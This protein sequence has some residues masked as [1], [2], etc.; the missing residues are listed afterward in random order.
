MSGCLLQ[1]RYASCCDLLMMLLGTLCAIAHGTALPLLMLFFGDLSDSFIYQDISSG[2]ARNVSNQTGMDINCSSIFN[3]TLNDVTFPDVNITSILQS[4]PNAG[5][6]DARCLLGAEFIS[7][8]NITVL[9][10][11]GIGVGVVIVATLQIC[12]FQFAAEQQVYN[13]RLRYYRAIMRQDIAWFDSNP[14]G[15]LVNRLSE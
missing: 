15:E 13:I 1:F 11:V 6:Q 14:T 7:E 8:I 5:F 10:F 4:L 3:Y 2:I 12:T 9:T